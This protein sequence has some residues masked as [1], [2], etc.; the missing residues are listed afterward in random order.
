VC[1]AVDSLFA[2]WYESADRRTDVT[3]TFAKQRERS[4]R[5]AVIGGFLLVAQ[6]VGAVHAHSL[7][8]LSIAPPSAASTGES[9]QCAI[10]LAT[11]HAPLATAV[12]G[13][14]VCT[15]VVVGATIEASANC[16]SSPAVAAPH[17]RAPPAAV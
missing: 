15:P 11:S 14:I 16:P 2:R 17:G 5:A 4:Q 10:C 12:A 1:V 6:F 8:S 7:P 13:S 3:I 9:G